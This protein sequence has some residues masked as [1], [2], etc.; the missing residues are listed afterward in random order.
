[1]IIMSILSIYSCMRY[2]AHVAEMDATEFWTV[3]W[4]LTDAEIVVNYLLP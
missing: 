4:K 3:I 2:M 1:M